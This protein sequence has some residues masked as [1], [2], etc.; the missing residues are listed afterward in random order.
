MNLHTPERHPNESQQQY[1][2]RQKQSRLEARRLTQ[3][4]AFMPRLPPNVPPASGYK[5]R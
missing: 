5:P 1:R 3:P 4:Q 2:S